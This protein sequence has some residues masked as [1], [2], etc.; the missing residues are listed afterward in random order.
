M[1]IAIAGGLGFIGSA[2]TRRALCAGHDVAILTRSN[3]LNHIKIHSRLNVLSAHDPGQKQEW[4]SIVSASDAVICAIG[5][6][7]PS[8]AMQEPQEEVSLNLVPAVRILHECV[9]SNAKKFILISSAGTVYGETPFDPATEDYR[10]NPA[11]LYG[12][13]KASQEMYTKAICA[14]SQVKALI[15]R[16]SNPYGPWQLP[17]YGQGLVANALRALSSQSVFKVWGTGDE[18]RDYIYI[19]DAADALVRL[20]E[21]EFEGTYNVSSG[22]SVSTMDIL[23]LLEQLTGKKIK[24]EQEQ[25]AFMLP[26]RVAICNNKIIRHTGWSPAISLREGLLSTI[27]WHYKKYSRMHDSPVK[28]SKEHLTTMLSGIA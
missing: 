20:C 9:S 1:K 21:P 14:K 4:L 2:V 18:K 11:G 10:L 8:K 24:K 26:G 3:S 27:E 5:G 19:D 28:L 6:G 12:A 25:I 13:T 17:G 22:S 15:V 7:G 23:D 16:L